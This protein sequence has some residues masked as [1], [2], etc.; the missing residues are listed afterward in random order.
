MKLPSGFFSL[1]SDS[2]K[3]RGYMISSLMA[4]ILSRTANEME[5]E[6][7]VDRGEGSGRP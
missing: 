5:D 3:S 7:L 6:E 1:L 2:P 4:G